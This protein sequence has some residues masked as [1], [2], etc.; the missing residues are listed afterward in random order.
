VSQDTGRERTGVEYRW[1]LTTDR[2]KFLRVEQLD[3][4]VRRQLFD[5]REDPFELR[6]VAAGHPEVTE[7]LAAALQLA[8]DAQRSKGSALRGGQPPATTPPDPVLLE[9]LRALGY[10]ER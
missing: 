2:W 7:P 10:V 5:H 9:Q 1:A 8:L 6:D 3:G 4:G